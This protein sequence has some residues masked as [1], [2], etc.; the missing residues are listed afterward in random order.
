L[1][2]AALAGGVGGARLADGLARCI[3]PDQLTVIVNTGDDFL[4]YGLAISPDL[5]T[6]MYNLAGLAHPVNGWGLDGDTA[7]MIG[8]MHRY[9]DDAWFGL[10]DRD[11]ATHLLRTQALRSGKLLHEITAEL[12]AALHVQVH[13]LPMS[14]DRVAT[15]VETVE[16][17]TL[18]F[19]EYFVRYR[20]QPTITAIR[21]DGAE[22]AAPAPGVLEA[23]DSA[24]LI[25]F[26]PSN[27]VLSVEPIL[28]IPGLRAAVQNRR[29]PS[30]AVSPL[31]G[32]NTVKGPAAKVMKELRL[33][34]TSLGI[35]A[36][37]GSL[38]DGLLIDTVDREL[39]EQI[40][41]KTR[42]TNIL[43][44]TVDDR[45]RLAHELIQWV[46]EKLS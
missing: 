42:V 15:V 21:Y 10:G 16:R 6:V 34:A 43:M 32:G 44:P 29:V 33:E 46:E 26:C 5:D 3:A 25:V 41:Q 28:R 24:D 8:M 37:Y 27:P 20:W 31:I 22:L 40:Q 11:L 36:Y 30:V 13:L 45:V 1:K 7:E 2:I 12:A 35:A 39:V 9:G 18:E 14:N 23:I 38:I 4:H 17:G 19:Q